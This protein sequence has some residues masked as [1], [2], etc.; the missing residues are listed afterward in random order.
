MSKRLADYPRDQ[1]EQMA[2][3]AIARYGGSEVARVFF[4]FTCD[5]CGERCTFEEP[6]ALFEVGVCHA[7]GHETPVVVAGFALQMQVGRTVLLR[8]GVTDE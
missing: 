2:L 7:C 8:N 1:I 5:A 4:K 3:Q 6:N